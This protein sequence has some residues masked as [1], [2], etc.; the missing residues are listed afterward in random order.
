[1]DFFKGFLGRFL[2]MVLLLIGL[3][4]AVLVAPLSCALSQS[5][6]TGWVLFV[7][8]LALLALGGTFFSWARRHM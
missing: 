7:V 2:G 6:T 4:V 5:A 8:G 3:F 1:M